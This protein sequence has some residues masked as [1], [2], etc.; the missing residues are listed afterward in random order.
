MTKIKM[1]I[2]KF[3]RWEI[4]KDM[5]IPNKYKLLKYC[6]YKNKILYPYDKCIH[7]VKFKKRR[8]GMK[9]IFNDKDVFYSKDKIK[10]CYKNGGEVTIED[11]WLSA[12]GIRTT[13]A[14]F[15]YKYIERIEKVK[16]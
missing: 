3:F 8:G 9:I 10:L 13:T 11:F 1:N 14:N 6:E 12:D 4:K 5:S 15:P 16:K 7:C 2:C